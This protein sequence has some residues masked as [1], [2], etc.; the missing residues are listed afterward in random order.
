MQA[1]VGS[2]KRAIDF[3]FLKQELSSNIVDVLKSDIDS[4]FSGGKTTALTT[5]IEG[6]EDFELISFIVI[7]EV[8]DAL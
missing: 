6:L 1:E 3:D 8:Q 2:L 5:K 7:Q 4:L